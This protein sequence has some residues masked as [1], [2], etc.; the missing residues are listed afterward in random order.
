MGKTIP[1][2]TVSIGLFESATSSIPDRVA[3]LLDKLVHPHVFAGPLPLLET[4]SD[5]E[6]YFSF[7]LPTAKAYTYRVFAATNYEGAATPKSLT[8]SYSVGAITSY[9]VRFVLPKIAAIALSVSISIAL[10][11]YD[12]KTGKLRQ[13]LKWFNEKNLRPFAVRLRLLLL[14]KWYNFRRWWRSR[15]S[16]HVRRY[17]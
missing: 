3:H 1:G 15:Q 16:R 4:T 10:F 12:R 11:I 9:F 5:K 8:I 6:G 14:L 17:R 2:Q 7:S 13:W